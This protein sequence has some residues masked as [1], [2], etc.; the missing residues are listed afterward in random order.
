MN[1]PPPNGKEVFVVSDDY[2]YMSALI[3][4]LMS[5]AKV[6]CSFSLPVP[7]QSQDLPGGKR[8]SVPR[9]HAEIEFRA[10]DSHIVIIGISVPAQMEHVVRHAINI[11]RKIVLICLSDASKSFALGVAKDVQMIVGSN[12]AEPP[13]NYRSIDC[14]T[15]KSGARQLAT[16]ILAL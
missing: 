8:I 5:G 12:F 4:A 13:A 16:N 7:C 2:R 15:E 9:D 10:E 11:Q 14:W 6:K 3:G 1:K